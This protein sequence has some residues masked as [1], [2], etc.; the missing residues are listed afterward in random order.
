MTVP[1]PCDELRARLSGSNALHAP[2]G[3]IF[4]REGE[5]ILG[6]ARA[7]CRDAATFSRDSDLVNEFAACWYALAWLDC[8]ECLGIVSTSG[9]RRE[10]PPGPSGIGP[11]E[12]EK[13]D[14]KTFRY[15]RLL[16]GACTGLEPA[17]ERE[18]VPCE[19]ADRVL[20]VGRVFLAWGG[21]YIRMGQMD[22]A[23]ACFS[24]GHGW[25]DCGVRTGLFRITG[26]RDLFTV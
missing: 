5:E 12:K 19:A 24:Y 20:T 21:E 25:L 8:G 2:E 23:L 4:H 18:T 7:Y 3:S 13:L 9:A 17:A 22:A 16:S 15:Q 10:W 14:E 26:E 6:M 11:E 1:S